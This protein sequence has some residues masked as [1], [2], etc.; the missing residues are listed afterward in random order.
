[1]L[2]RSGPQLFGDLIVAGLVDELC[3]TLSPR[4]VLGPAGRI[5]SG[6]TELH[7]RPLRLTSAVHSDNELM[8]RYRRAELA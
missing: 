2:F 1:V 4:L 5:A 7:D 3:L 6:L 8:L